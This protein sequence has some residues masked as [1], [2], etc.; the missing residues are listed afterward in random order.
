MSEASID[1]GQLEAYLRAAG[2]IPAD[3]TGDVLVSASTNDGV[4]T[5]TITV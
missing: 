1:P 2:L 4:E 3:Y 5:V